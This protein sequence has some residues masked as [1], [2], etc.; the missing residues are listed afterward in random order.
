MIYYAREVGLA[1]TSS[2]SLNGNSSTRDFNGEVSI[3]IDSTPLSFKNCLAT[4]NSEAE[5]SGSLIFSKSF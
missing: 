2:G 3:A 1:L 4:F 5:T